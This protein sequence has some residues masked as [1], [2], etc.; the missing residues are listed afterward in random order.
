MPTCTYKFVSDIVEEETQQKAKD[1]QA[2]AAISKK[3]RG[4]K[5]EKPLPNNFLWN[6]LMKADIDCLGYC[7]R[8]AV[9]ETM[10]EEELTEQQDE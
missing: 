2:K 9:Q 7:C 4:M 5:N 6:P 8:G 3:K 10:T 1:D